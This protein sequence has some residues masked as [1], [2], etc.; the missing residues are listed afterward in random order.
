MIFRGG[1]NSKGWGANLL[2]GQFFL[3]KLYENKRNWTGEVHGWRPIGL[4]Y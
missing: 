4:V 3:R 1:D 2:L